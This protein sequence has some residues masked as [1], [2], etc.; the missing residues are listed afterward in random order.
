MFQILQPTQ[1]SFP[2]FYILFFFPLSG[3]SWGEG[4]E[5]MCLCVFVMDDGCAFYCSLL[6]L[7]LSLY[8]KSE[9]MASTLVVSIATAASIIVSNCVFAL[10]NW[11][12]TFSVSAAECKWIV[13][14]QLMICGEVEI[15][16]NFA[17]KWNWNSTCMWMEG[18]KFILLDASQS[19]RLDILTLAKFLTT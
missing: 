13:L 2:F 14:F 6:F 10:E 15:E 19:T 3:V 11:L 18:K 1:K 8:P 5:W 9:F 17:L 16:M 4:W 7:L 12:Q